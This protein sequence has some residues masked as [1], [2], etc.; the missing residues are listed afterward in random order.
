MNLFHLIKLVKYNN[1]SLLIYFQRRGWELNLEKF[2]LMEMGEQYRFVGVNWDV[3][4]GDDSPAY[5][6]FVIS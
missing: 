3:I 4:A 2:Q 5:E 1:L 6:E